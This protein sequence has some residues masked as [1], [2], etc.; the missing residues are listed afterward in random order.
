[1]KLKTYK[2]IG[3]LI[4]AFFISGLQ[5]QKFDKKYNETFKVNKNVLLAIN[6][7]NADIN[8]STWN[9][10]EVSVKAVITVE[11]LSKKEA[12]KFLKNWEFEAL[13]NKSKVQINA[14][15]NHFLHFGDDAFKFDFD[16]GD[17]VIPDINFDNFKIEIPEF[18][19][20]DINLDFSEIWK[21]IDEYDFDSDDHDG[22]K[23][24][25]Y[26]SNGKHKTIVIKSKK[27]WEK[28]K[29]SGEYAKM[30]KE[31]KRTLKKATQKIK[32][33]DMKKIH[34]QI[35][36]AEIR[37][38][39]INKKQIEAQIRRAKIQYEKIDKVKIK[40]SLAAAKMSI[41]MMK[42][43]MARRYRNGDNVIIIEDG[44]SKKKIKITRKITIKVPKNA[45]FDLNTRHS[46]VKLPKG[47]TS[48]KV[49]YGTF[50]ADEINGGNLNIHFAPVIID[51][52]KGS[53]VTL[54]NITDATIASVM[55]TKLISSSSKLRIQNLES[56]VEL[57]S[58]FGELVIDKVISSLKGLKL[59][60][61]YS[62]AT[63]NLKN[64]NETLKILQAT[65]V[66][67]KNTTK[68]FRLNG[69]FSLSN[70]KVNIKGKQSEL[71]VK[72]Q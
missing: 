68:N 54:N 11:G 61:S 19:M 17:I 60:L 36:K 34:E 25:R 48:G 50:N 32:N 26:E 31:L 28:F 49:S 52:L 39:K 44:N 59:N 47:K 64:L 27:E 66:S 7:S 14:N 43:T 67:S 72:K 57:T 15:A 46:K 58:K 53:T 51:V 10:N 20:P 33:I 5:A 13:G 4:A 30:K 2:C 6:A 3:F 63:I 12:Q 18:E 42:H 70:S 55:N 9:R 71:K 24:F 40:E 38:Q 56:N 22:T 37:M 65:E 62:D 16:F 8:V 69:N 1:M 41:E 23:T 21:E 45:R 35:N 29:K